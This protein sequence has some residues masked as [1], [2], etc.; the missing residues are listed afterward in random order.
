MV[1]CVRGE[2]HELFIAL[3][4]AFSGD[5]QFPPTLNL[6]LWT[7]L[8]HPGPV[9][10]RSGKQAGHSHLMQNSSCCLQPQWAWRNHPSR[11]NNTQRL[12][13]HQRSGLCCPQWSS[14]S[15]QLVLTSLWYFRVCPGFFPAT[16]KGIE[17]HSSESL[18]S[19]CQFIHS[20]PAIK[21]RS[22]FWGVRKGRAGGKRA[23]GK[24]LGWILGRNSSVPARD[25]KSDIQDWSRSSS[26]KS[27]FMNKANK[28]IK[29]TG[30]ITPIKTFT[31]L[32]IFA[33]KVEDV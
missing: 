5:R 27:Y 4:W 21:S 20:C 8:T 1:S 32:C 22:Q 15:F 17:E 13:G 3:G 31:K 29:S 33:H 9:S 24:I 10:H 12:Y 25:I 6:S 11:G 30:E 16:Q 28:C 26:T 18:E 2:Q 14:V 23:V 7:I 19:L